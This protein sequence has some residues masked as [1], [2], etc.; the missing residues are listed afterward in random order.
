MIAPNFASLKLIQKLRMCTK[1]LFL[2]FFGYVVYLQ[3]SCFSITT[4][5]KVFDF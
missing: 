1:V 3:S 2:V 5:F 4:L